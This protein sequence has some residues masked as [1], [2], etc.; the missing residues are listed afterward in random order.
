[1]RENNI[2]HE[3]FDLGQ[4]SER[5]R[6][7]KLCHR[8][9]DLEYIDMLDRQ[10]EELAKI[11][12]LGTP[13]TPEGL[14]AEIESI[15][16]VQGKA[17]YGTW[18]YY[19]WTRRVVRLLAERDFAQVRTDRNQLKITAEEQ[20]SLSQKT[21][22]LVGLS[23]GHAVAMTLA[24]ERSFG[25]LRIADFDLLDL[26]NLNRIRSGVQHIGISKTEMAM[27]EIAEL[28]PYLRIER[29]DEGLTADNMESF[30]EGLDLLIDECD[31]LDI[32]IQVREAARSEQI[33]VIM[34]TSD[35]GMLDVERFDLE[36][37]PILHGL[38]EGLDLT[39]TSK[40]TKAE[41]VPI[42]SRIIGAEHASAGIKRSFPEIG[43]T[44]S[45]WPQLGSD[46]TLG[47]AS[48]AH[49]AKKI[50]LGH[51]LA[52]GRYYIDLDLSTLA[53]KRHSFHSMIDHS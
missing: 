37:R 12:L 14:A 20:E 2:H 30:L 25:T 31:S 17:N 21:I 50:L 29:Y 41:L 32:K 51:S 4:S 23:V 5:E 42:I 43:K 27:R 39:D 18:V 40:M 49:A 33:P 1:M 3:I 13:L 10:L 9:D 19:P 16:G 26:S 36:D 38:V 47:G 7:E 35:R 6:F 22:G 53:E 8:H 48:I 24:L 34:E 45:T 44:I 46:V 28:D 52:H 15:V 11:R